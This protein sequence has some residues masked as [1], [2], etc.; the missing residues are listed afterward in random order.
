MENDLGENEWFVWEK[1]RWVNRV[2][3][4]LSMDQLV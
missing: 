2:G 4:F 1:D 3:F